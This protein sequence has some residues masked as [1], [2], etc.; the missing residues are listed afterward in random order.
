MLSDYA[1]VIA[2]VIAIVNSV[3]A[4]SVSHFKP[5]RQ[6]LKIVLLV[7]SIAFGLAAAA[8]TIY[9]QYIVVK[10]QEA[11]AARRIEIHKRLGEL[12]AQGDVILL[13][14]TAR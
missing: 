12:I 5:E 2:P 8:G 13:V 9:G 10:K 4:V 3:I 14:L 11:E 6:R 1:N 7:A